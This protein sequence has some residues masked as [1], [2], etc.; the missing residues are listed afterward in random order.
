MP[1][2]V[3]SIPAVLCA[4]MV[5]FWVGEVERGGS[6][7]QSISLWYDRGA[8]N[9]NDEEHHSLEMTE[10]GLHQ[11][12]MNER[13]RNSLDVCKQRKTSQESGTNAKSGQLSTDGS[14]A[15]VK[16]DN[17]DSTM[18]ETSVSLGSDR[19]ATTYAMTFYDQYI[20]PH[21]T[22][23]KALFQCP[24]VVLA[25]FQGAPGCKYSLLSD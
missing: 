20:Q 16:L 17:Q 24:S 13:V 1:F 18:S 23:L 22:T 19:D 8:I 11:N 4:F 14:G 3:V 7:K 2:L 21:F 10:L 9:G 5:W 25:I 15:Y 12:R 6:E